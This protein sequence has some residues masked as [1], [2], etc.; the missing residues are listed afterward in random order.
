MKARWSAPAALVALLALLIV[1]FAVGASSAAGGSAPG[2]NAQRGNGLIDVGPDVWNGRLPLLQPDGRVVNLKIKK[3]ALSKAARKRLLR[4]AGIRLMS[5]PPTVGEERM[6]VALDFTAGSYRKRFTLRAK[7]NNIEVWVASPVPRTA[8]GVTATGLD[9]PVGDCRN[10]VRTTITDAQVNYLAQQFDENILPKESA[11]FSVAP[12][13][14]G[15]QYFTGPALLPLDGVSAD[16]TGDGDD[17]VVL[18]DNVRDENFRDFNN[19]H[20]LTR[21]AGFFSSGLNE[22]FDRNIMTIDAYD[23]L[24]LTG[25]DPPHEPSSDP[26][27]NAPARPFLYEGVFAHE[28]QHLLEYYENNAEV[29]WVNEGLA[30][31]AQTL[32]GYVDPS[33]PVTAKGFDSHVQCFLGWLRQQ[34]T[35]N[36]IPRE[37]SGPENSLTLWGDQGPDELLCEYGAAYTFMEY[38]HGQFGTNFMTRLHREDAIGLPGF[39]IVLDQAGSRRDSDEI[40]HDW[41]AMVA[42]D[43]LLDQGRNVQGGRRSRYQT[44]T[45]NATIDWDNPHAFSTP[46]AP[47][48]GS[49][50]IRLRGAAGNPLGVKDIKQLAFNGAATHIPRPVAWTVDANPPGQTGDAALYS[51][52]GDNRDEAIVRSVSVPTGAGASLTFNARWNL[53]EDSGGPWDFGF[54]QASTDGGETY[55]SLACT[56]TRTDH[57]PGAIPSVVANLPGFSGDSGGWKA[58]TCS[59]AAYAGQT[60]LLSFRTINDPNTQGTD[61]NIPAGFWVDDVAVGGTLISDGSSLA[62]WQSPTQVNPIEVHGFTVQLVAW[63]TQG[64]SPVAIARLSLN[65]NFDATRS[66]QQLQKRLGGARADFVGAIVTYDEPTE[67][68]TDYAPYTLMVN[69]VTQPGGSS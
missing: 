39:D 30:D 47:P 52:T 5:H 41:A 35:F 22:L 68:I 15:S 37:A 31:W 7:R 8:F 27:L 19:A 38:V 43:G 20:S 40:I 50:Y 4:R 28:Y 26:C 36:P 45:L 16:P 14:N 57:N 13:R 61:P 55:T 2:L 25:A 23:W 11:T 66:G 59:L 56:D 51:G 64:K 12:N 67:S 17:T 44:P 49:D 1:A 65:G 53:E 24:H 9:F 48:N 42:I 3:K 18:I 6:W 62:G 34:T 60:V 33:R 63:K 29:N 54:V 10:G 46:G 21:V 32:T 69:G 58:E